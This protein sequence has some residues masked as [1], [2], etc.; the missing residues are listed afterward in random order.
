MSESDQKQ[1]R[2]FDLMSFYTGGRVETIPI[3]VLTIS[4]THI[5]THTHAAGS[6]AEKLPLPNQ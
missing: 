3:F 1:S 5:H 4:D 6:A 2:D